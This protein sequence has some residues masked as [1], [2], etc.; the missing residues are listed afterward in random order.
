MQQIELTCER[1][2][3]L[4]Q[5]GESSVWSLRS[6]CMAIK[7]PAGFLTHLPETLRGTEEAE[8][9]PGLSAPARGWR[10]AEQAKEAN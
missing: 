10:E 9:S 1:K 5:E 6:V 4:Q 7:A 3:G 2:D 8:E